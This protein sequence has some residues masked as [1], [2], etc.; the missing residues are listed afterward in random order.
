[1]RDLDIFNEVMGFSPVTETQ[2][3]E[4]EEPIVPSSGND[5]NIFSDVMG[6]APPKRTEVKTPVVEP[7]PEEPLETPEKPEITEPEIPEKT[8]SEEP[9]ATSTL[10]FTE[11]TE[12]KP[13]GLTEKY[14]P[15]SPTPSYGT[16]G[17]PMAPPP[18][19][20]IPEKAAAY[21]HR[22]LA[23]GKKLIAPEVEKTAFLQP[24]KEKK[25]ER[26]K[27]A[28][29]LPKEAAIH[30]KAAE[31]LDPTWY[32][33]EKINERIERI[34]DQDPNLA[35][36]F[37]M[38]DI[39]GAA[40]INV[41][42][43]F[44]SGDATAKNIALDTQR[45]AREAAGEFQKKREDRKGLTGQAVNVLESVSGMLPMM[46]K[47][48]AQTAVPVV[49]PLISSSMWAKQGAGDII[50]ELKEKDVDDDTALAYGLAGGLAY[51]LV[52]QVQV[53]RVL[54]PQVKKAVGNSVKKKIAAIAKEKGIDWFKNVREEVIQGLVTENAIVSALKES[55]IEVDSKEVKDR[56]QKA[57]KENFIGSAWP[58]AVLSA[59]G[60]SGG[61]A[62]VAYAEGAKK[63]GID[64]K[65]ESAAASEAVP[66]T[67]P[68]VASEVSPEI[69]TAPPPAPEVATETK[70][71]TLADYDM[72]VEEFNSLPE[73][74]QYDIAKELSPQEREKILAQEKPAEQVT[75]AEEAPPV[76]VIAPEADE[77]DQYEAET[78][79]ID[80]A[81]LPSVETV[82]E[83]AAEQP[84]PA[85]EEMAPKEE[86]EI[87]KE[88]EAI[89]REDETEK[90]EIKKVDVAPSEAQKEAGN[91]R[92][93]HIKRDGF[94]ISVENPAGS[95]RSGT[96]P[97]GKKWSQKINHDY[98]YIRGTKGADAF[99][100]AG[101]TDQVD[102]FIKP[103]STEGGNVY[104]IN[105]IDPASGK[106]DEH[107]VMMGFDSQEEAEKAYLSNYEKGWKGLESTV[108]MPMDEFKEWVYT[109][110][111]E[112]PVEPKEVKRAEEIGETVRETGEEKRPVR[113]EERRI[114]VRDDEESGVATG[115]GK[116]V[117]VS[118]KAALKA[119]RKINT[120]RGVSVKETTLPKPVSEANQ[121]Y[122]PVLN[123]SKITTGWLR[124]KDNHSVIIDPKTGRQITFVADNPNAAT[125][126]A[127]TNTA[128]HSHAISNP[129]IEKGEYTE[130]TTQKV[131][132]RLKLEEEPILKEEKSGV[133]ETDRET[134]VSPAVVTEGE[135]PAAKAKQKK[136]EVARGEKPVR[137]RLEAQQK[138]GRAVR[139]KSRRPASVKRV[140][141]EKDYT[142]EYWKAQHGHHLNVEVYNALKD[143]WTDRAQTDHPGRQKG[144]VDD[145]N[146]ITDSKAPG[147][148]KNPT[149][150][151]NAKQWLQEVVDNIAENPDYIQELNKIGISEPQHIDD[152]I[153]LLQGSMSAA[154]FTRFHN[155]FE[156][157]IREA[158]VD[159][160][161]YDEALR[162]FNEEPY[163]LTPEQRNILEKTWNTTVED[164]VAAERGEEK[165]KKKALKPDDWKQQDLFG[166]EKS[167]K[168]LE[169]E[170]RARA[171]KEDIEQKTEERK[172][173][174][175]S[176]AGLPM[177]EDQDI[178]GS[179]QTIKFEG[180]KKSKEKPKFAKGEKVS[181]TPAEKKITKEEKELTDI[182]FSSVE[183]P[184]K[185]GT[186]QIVTD[187]KPG[188][189]IDAIGKTIEETTGKKVVFIKT[190]DRSLKATLKFSIDGL[191]IPGETEG[192]FKDTIFVNVD[193]TRPIMWTAYHEFAHFLETNPNYKKRFWG[194]VR[195]TD[196]GM[197]ELAKE[198]ESELTADVIGEMMSRQD[199]WNNLAKQGRTPFQKVMQEFLRIINKIRNSIRS[200]IG[201]DKLP[202]Y[203]NLLI[204]TNSARDEIAQIYSD[205]RKTTGSEI[206]DVPARMVAA[207]KKEKVMF[208]K[209]KSAEKKPQLPKRKIGLLP[210]KKEKQLKVSDI[211]GASK[212]A[213]EAERIFEKQNKD[214]RNKFNNSLKDRLK[215]VKYFLG[216]KIWDRVYYAKNM[217]G[218]TVEAKNV[219][220]KVNASKGNSANAK[221]VYENAEEKI[222]ENLP[223]RLE[224][225]LA[226]Y[227]EA[228][229]IVEIEKIKGEG[230]VK[231]TGGMTL[232]QAEAFVYA[233][234]NNL[235]KRDSL[236][237]KIAAGRYWNAMH[238]QLKALRDSGIISEN[239]YK[240]LS[241]EGKHYSPRRFLQH[242]DPEKNITT[243]SGQK[244]SVRES[245]IQ[246][247]AEG[248]E[249]AMVNNWRLLLSDVI[250]RTQSRVFKND[251]AKALGKFVESNPDNLFGGEI[252]QPAG[253]E[254]DLI[255]VE[256][257]VDNLQGELVKL[258]GSLA[259]ATTGAQTFAIENKIDDTVEK[260][261][262]W[263]E[264]IQA[265]RTKGEDKVFIEYKKQPPLPKGSERIYF[266]EDGDTKAVL[267][268][269]KFADS[270]NQNDVQINR[271][272]ANFLNTI[273]G[274]ALVRPFATGVFAPEFA[275]SNIPRDMALQW[276]AT[277]EY[278]KAAPV[279]VIQNLD[280]FRRVLKDAW[281]GTGRYEEYVKQGGGMEFLNEQG[282][283]F[284]K[285]P[286]KGVSPTSIRNKK[287]MDAMRKLQEFSERLT[288]LALREQ[289]I[290]NGKTPQEAT[291]IAREYLD[292]AQG[293]SLIKAL[294]NAVPYLNASVQGTRSVVEA[295]VDDPATFS[296]KAAQLIT[297]GA[298]LALTAVK[299]RRKE[300]DEIS[301][302][303]KVGRWNFP[304]GYSYKNKYGEENHVYLS[305]PKDQS[306]R[307]FAT[308]G[309]TIIER[310][311]G[312]I[313]GETA[314]HRI[315][316]AFDDMSP[317]DTIGMLPPTLSALIGY[318]LN[319]NF[320]KEDKIWKGREV[321]PYKEVYEGRTPEFYADLAKGLNKIGVELSPERMHQS[322]QQVMPR[323]LLTSLMGG[324]Y[325]GVTAA[326]SKEDKQKL[327]KMTYDHW[328]KLPGVRKYFRATYPSKTDYQKAF[329]QAVDYDIPLKD[330]KGHRKSEAQIKH[331]IE[332]KE[333]QKNDIR[334]QHDNEAGIVSE[335]L[336]TGKNEDALKR[337]QQ[338]KVEAAKTMGPKEIDRINKRIIKRIEKNDNKKIYRTLFK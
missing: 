112:K 159:L 125:A 10:E 298:A 278:S 219:I 74:V 239:L 1:M 51:A 299:F 335:L 244:I 133:S 72:D 5:E 277:Q 208:A 48:A 188:S 55:G 207:I 24:G 290:K 40:D 236:A 252:E 19:V 190:D 32:T 320:W 151:D 289:A 204:D 57:I 36:S 109:D 167:V 139:A 46:G 132:K 131:R 63:E 58:M 247:L 152:V 42:N 82:S 270:W 107:K 147:G 53:G 43:A 189:D 69:P 117:K 324:A 123:L 263:G 18:A 319:I 316:M 94:E 65:M 128:A 163:N 279:A 196:R 325:E 141:E 20:G 158:D 85:P 177:F 162:V 300:W 221:M 200:I 194:A 90:E 52:E 201:S 309:E 193:S 249:E 161:Q 102:V 185:Y 143:G 124:P 35:N 212:E 258:Q 80:I 254:M 120:P 115:A 225:V 250:S 287:F 246:A 242:I 116:E 303:E 273:L 121:N 67:V 195:L 336:L 138:R 268:P 217:L 4:P 70:Y 311:Q 37:L 103:N 302:R 171:E 119:K 106:F 326:L 76:E 83:P 248:S 114:R 84:A 14:V 214:V 75:V 243:P 79:L 110:A 54:N 264:K 260:I 97:S 91:Y 230:K 187:I 56:Y 154:E 315:R 229:R 216:E 165:Q 269:K 322:L 47:G 137:Q 330:K 313:D 232:E 186:I 142:P 71:A 169:A 231:H 276:I 333:Q 87:K 73:D 304:L 238:G 145:Y 134:P 34:K 129:L 282:G 312:S 44:M 93:A 257:I 314:W 259:K 285:D 272:T 179:Q 140:A 317:I 11:P 288:R 209:K 227:I 130:T 122:E 6:F 27:A 251:A 261:D 3:E 60:L 9:A 78:Q 284:R 23:A 29:E 280:N 50:T 100:E 173:G 21:T 183:T 174:E 104:V 202:Q 226:N 96:D 64:S 41:A 26:A 203:E 61:A 101:N 12:I 262:R 281:H 175:P 13:T 296:I 181:E 86:T 274:G 170:E 318:A 294:D 321:S 191:S 307:I 286:T 323:S 88:V 111:T 211:T 45:K 233:V 329:E 22:A 113:G 156:R 241:S 95:Q 81:D 224:E 223:F 136:K 99:R 66:E 305:I 16:F 33:S 228:K 149:L 332:K 31:Y 168:Q 148:T 271:T 182:V 28:V 126:N 327:D 92:K 199:F 331:E 62:R 176:I 255:D 301:D 2:V 267:V 297:M 334:Q 25:E 38:G 166:K 15:P 77:V 17:V 237:I 283:S 8:T 135:S 178:E 184:P 7:P 253:K 118:R 59:V 127:L 105:Q 198:G 295:A 49:G 265:A 310:L 235:N 240:K 180:K 337:W 206:G 160:D 108:E 222:T 245:G 256:S 150:S 328:S 291:V 89:P 153:A 68:D 157:N 213:L 306:S 197:A 292:F 192:T 39:T 308:I 338:L 220:G 215:A 164:A 210:G 205:Y 146:I 98:G 234:E 293:G 144:W 155:E 30:G 218:K 172:G 266:I 275:L